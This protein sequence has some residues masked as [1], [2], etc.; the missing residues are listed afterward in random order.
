MNAFQV[1]FRYKDKEI[2]ELLKTITILVD[3]REQKNQHIIDYFESKK[4]PYESLKVDAGDYSVKLPQNIELGI[5]RDIY[6][7]VAIERKNSV[8]ELVQTIKERSRFENELIR[9]RKLQFLL[10]VEDPNGYENMLYGNYQ[11]QYEPKAFLGSLKSF[12]T[13]YEFSTVFIPSKVSGNYIYHHFYYFV[14]NFLKGG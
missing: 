1:H 5:P 10:M 9:S 6:F 13:R 7:P 11:S 12:E 8:D 3:T 4:I 2:A 14:R